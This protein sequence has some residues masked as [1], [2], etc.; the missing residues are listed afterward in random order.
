MRR[1]PEHPLI[2]TM[3]WVGLSILLPLLPVMVGVALNIM[4]REAVSFYRLLDGIELFLISLWLVTATAWDLS[5]HDFKWEKPL[6][7]ALI[8]LAIIDLIF[9]ILI[10]VNNRVRSLDLDK[11]AYLT[12]AMAHFVAVV[13]IAVA[14]QFFMSYTVFEGYPKGETQC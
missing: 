8:G 10:Y 13:F 7:M 12:I 1:Q 6:R 3:V 5:K 4:Q 2:H 9:L 14:L 11:E